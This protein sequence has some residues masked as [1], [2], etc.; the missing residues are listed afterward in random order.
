MHHRRAPYTVGMG[1]FMA[2]TLR[3]AF[4]VTRFSFWAGALLSSLVGSVLYIA[5]SHSIEG[6][7]E[8][9]FVNHARHAQSVISVRVKSY[10]DLLR[11]AGSM[12]QSSDIMTPRRF[13]EY[14]RGL[15]LQRNYPAVDSMNFAAYVTDADRS[16]F[17]N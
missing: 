10:T 2:T 4:S 14:V 6:D 12:L 15:E 16:A 7:A 8:T 11:A 5:T 9:R 1:F 17:M 3:D 13:H